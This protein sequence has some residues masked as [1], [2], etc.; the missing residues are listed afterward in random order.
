M[1]Q[2]PPYGPPPGPPGWGPLPPPQGWPF[3]GQPPPGSAPQGPQQPWGPPPAPAPK[4]KLGCITA[5]AGCCLLGMVGS[6]LGRSAEPAGGSGGSAPTAASAPDASQVPAPP[7]EVPCPSE[8]I[9][10]FARAMDDVCTR[11]GR[12]LECP[13]W[14][15]IITDA[16]MICMS[17]GRLQIRV[18]SQILDRNPTTEAIARDSCSRVNAVAW[19]SGARGASVR[20]NMA[21]GRVIANNVARPGSQC[22]N[23]IFW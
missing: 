16:E 4:R 22:I 7:S 5:L 18:T 19:G 6:V 21:D 3:Q 1:N 11:R 2:P 23:G 10:A 12:Q 14:R 20:Y 17:N 9:M 8:R 15:A 13:E